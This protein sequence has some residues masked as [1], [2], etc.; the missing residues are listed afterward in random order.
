MQKLFNF[1]Y[2]RLFNGI[3]EFS[4][5]YTHIR[6]IEGIGKKLDL[7]IYFTRLDSSVKLN[8][9]YKPGHHFIMIE[10]LLCSV[11]FCFVKISKLS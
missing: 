2:S 6:F 5:T 3:W 10:I 8:L 9:R 4:K 1:E 7:A 11:W